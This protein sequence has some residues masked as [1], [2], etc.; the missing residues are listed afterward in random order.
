MKQ[1]LFIALLGLLIGCTTQASNIGSYENDNFKVELV[2]TDASLGSRNLTLLF[3]GVTVVED[4]FS[5]E[6]VVSSD[7]FDVA[8]FYGEWRG[9]PVE[10][11]RVFPSFGSR[12]LG[13]IRKSTVT[14]EVYVNS[15]LVSMLE[16]L[17]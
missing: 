5:S 14:Y 10:L 1:I 6:D 2:Q 16:A 9:M 11:R 7:G 13:T 8:S 4:N 3:D 15:E 12:S 17:A